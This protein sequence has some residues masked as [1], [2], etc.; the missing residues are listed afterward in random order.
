MG[1]VPGVG[2]ATTLYE[3]VWGRTLLTG[4]ELEIGERVLAM[5][6]LGFLGQP[7]WKRVLPK[8]TRWAKKLLKGKGVL[9]PKQVERLDKSARNFWTKSTNFRGNKVFQRDD[10]INPNLVDSRTGLTNLELMRSGRAPIG[11]DNKPVNLHHLTQDKNG[12]I[13]EMLQSFHQ[14]NSRVIHIN[15]SSVPSGID[16]AEFRQWRE[17]YWKSRANDF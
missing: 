16:R 17:N 10:L 4:E 7:L 12:A 3:A 2:Q 9:K 1:L 13:A 15:P 11:P 14:T 6:T 8:I 5:S